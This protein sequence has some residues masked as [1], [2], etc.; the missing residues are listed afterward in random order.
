MGPKSYN[1]PPT[2]KPA[3]KASYRLRFDPQLIVLVFIVVCTAYVLG[4]LY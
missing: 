2:E 3:A 4:M 1:V